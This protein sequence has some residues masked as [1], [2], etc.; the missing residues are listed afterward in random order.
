[1]A[2]PCFAAWTRGVKLI[3]AVTIA[4]EIGD[5]ARFESAADLMGYLGLVPSE[6]STGDRVNRGGITKAGNRRAR[7]I[8]VEA[9]WTYRHPRP[10][11]SM[12]PP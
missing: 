7:R 11:V 5:L 2:A 9:S 1:M 4:A 8:L 6:R 12:A 10:C 3:A